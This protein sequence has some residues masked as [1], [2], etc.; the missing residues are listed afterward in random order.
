MMRA[1]A[2]IEYVKNEAQKAGPE[3]VTALKAKLAA[4]RAELL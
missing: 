1:K 3:Q 4:S 2:I